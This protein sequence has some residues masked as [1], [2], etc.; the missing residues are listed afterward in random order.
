[1]N[2]FWQTATRAF[3]SSGRDLKQE[4]PVQDIFIWK[5]HIQIVCAVLC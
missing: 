2:V 1:M 4:K 5:I 3:V